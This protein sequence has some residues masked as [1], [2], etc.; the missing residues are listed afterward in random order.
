M[1]WVALLPQAKLLCYTDVNFILY[2]LTDA[3]TT[4]LPSE[5]RQYHPPTASL[6]VHVRAI[7]Q[8][9]FLPDSTRLV[10]LSTNGIKGITIANSGSDLDLITL[11]TGN[12][13]SHFSC[14][15]YNMAAMIHFWPAITIFHYAWPE[16]NAHSSFYK[17]AILPQDKR[18]SDPNL[19]MDLSS[20]RVVVS[21]NSR[22]KQYV[23]DPFN[24]ING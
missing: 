12:I 20:G 16:E 22:D 2:D 11:F 19:F 5:V 18:F 21:G 6:I 7:S 14:M 24:L 1:Q 4:T 3:P 9:Y 15:G 23:L 10:F 17:H 13:L 8:P